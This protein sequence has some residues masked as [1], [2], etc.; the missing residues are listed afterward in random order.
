MQAPLWQ[1]C[2]GTA[3]LART[4]RIMA[5]QTRAASASQARAELGCLDPCCRF[6]H[7]AD[8]SSAGRWQ[9]HVCAAAARRECAMQGLC[10]TSRARGLST[11]TFALLLT[12][13]L[14]TACSGCF[15]LKARARPWCRRINS[16]PQTLSVWRWHSIGAGAQSQAPCT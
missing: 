11:S 7:G 4:R 8:C 14:P 2:S 1:R 3:S 6:A 10:I 9:A 15:R 16:A 12:R 5:P 13:W